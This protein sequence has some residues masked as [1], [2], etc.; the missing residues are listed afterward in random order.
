MG[1]ATEAEATCR[2]WGAGQGDRDASAEM[3]GAGQVEGRRPESLESLEDESHQRQSR[4]T[5][6]AG[7][8]GGEEGRGRGAGPEAE[9]GSGTGEGG[10]RSERPCEGQGGRPR[11]AP[12]VPT[13]GGR[14]EAETH[15]R[16]GAAGA[17]G[18]GCWCS[19]LS[20]CPRPAPACTQS[21][22]PPQTECDGQGQEPMG[23]IGPLLPASQ[24]GGQSGSGLRGRE[25]LSVMPLT[26][27]SPP[28]V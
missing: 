25:G 4:K 18:G 2:K 27:L 7:R 28:A 14:A 15:A 11:S 6:R 3:R 12:G 24:S 8:R 9:R 26:G 20:P 19:G 22:S 10:C 5:G 13:A 16:E 21:R 23:Q 1:E 17:S